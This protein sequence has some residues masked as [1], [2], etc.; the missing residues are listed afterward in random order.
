[1]EE[2]NL[3]SEIQKS[4][5][6]LSEVKTCFAVFSDGEQNNVCIGGL[7]GDIIN[8][9]ANMFIE[10]PQLIELLEPAIRLVAKNKEKAMVKKMMSE[11]F[12]LTDKEECP[13]EKCTCKSKEDQIEEQLEEM[14]KDFFRRMSKMMKN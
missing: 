12:G 11:L 7:G 4:L 14:T 8:I 1:M 3:K 10:S 5:N 9:L 6:S 2:K 13:V